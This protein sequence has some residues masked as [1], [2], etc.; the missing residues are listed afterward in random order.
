MDEN[1]YKSPNESAAPSAPSAMQTNWRRLKGLAASVLIA[2]ILGMVACGWLANY[3]V[4]PA[5]IG[6]SERDWG[7]RHEGYGMSSLFVGLALGGLA[8]WGAFSILFPNRD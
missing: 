1:P 8:G 7:R 6:V 2:S 3:L 4:G 5:P